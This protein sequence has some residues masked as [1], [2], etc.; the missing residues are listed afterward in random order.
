MNPMTRIEHLSGSLSEGQKKLAEY[1]LN[2]GSSLAMMTAW[3]VARAVGV[4]ESTVIRFAKGLGYKGFPNL[5]RE[6]RKELT[7]K[8]KATARMKQTLSSIGR[9]E[10]I[11]SKLMEQDIQLLTE[12]RA[13]ISGS[14]FDNAVGTILRA[15]KI[16][17]IGFG[18]SLALASFLHFRLTRLGMDVHW[19]FVT[20]G[21]SF[22]EQLAL[23]RRQDLLIVIGFLQASREIQM[24]LDH[25][26]KLGVKVLG[27]TDLPNTPIGRQADICLFA[28]RGL[29]TT[30]VSLT[31]P[32]SLANALVIAVAW[33]RKRDSMKALRNLDQLLETYSIKSAAR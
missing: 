31:A 11:V 20:A 29:H 15:R 22:I 19:I 9:R 26:N 30:L 2:D 10:N 7:A 33:T 17:V 8:F 4:S 12:T 21:T 24:A 28:K 3:E 5:K 6:L 18:S 23:M 27:I 16:F 13:T 32:F 25:A 14:A 1:L